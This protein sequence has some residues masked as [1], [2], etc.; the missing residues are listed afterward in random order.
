MGSI[1]A[2]KKNARN[3]NQLKEYSIKKNARNGRKLHNIVDEASNQWQKMKID[4]RAL[5]KHMYP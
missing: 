5:Q 1:T 4:K 2:Y 3:T